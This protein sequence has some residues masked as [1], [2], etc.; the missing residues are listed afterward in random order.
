MTKKAFID[1]SV[2]I[3]FFTNDDPEKFQDCLEFFEVVESGKIRPYISQ[4][5]IFEIV[6]VL[7]RLYSFPKEK[8]LLA[9][10]EICNIR[11]ITVIEVTNT[12]S[13]LDLYGVY[14]I[15]YQDCLIVTQI[16]QG[17]TLV[18]Y[19][20]EFKRVPTITPRTPMELVSSG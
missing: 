20:D 12:R 6:F 17:C 8:I 5:V 14:S 2:F 9:I 15:K 16:P 10:D 7:S 18:T 4:V 11:N 1:T 19:D 13:A 3:R